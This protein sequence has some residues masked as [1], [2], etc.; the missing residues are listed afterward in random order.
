LQLGDSNA[1]TDIEYLA[2]PKPGDFDVAKTRN[3]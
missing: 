2:I 1:I 3:K